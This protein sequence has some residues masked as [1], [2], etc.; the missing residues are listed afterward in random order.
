MTNGTLASMII[1]DLICYRES[2][3]EDI[4]NPSRKGS[5]FTTEFITQNV[6]GLGSI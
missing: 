2:K 3:F 6:N 5:V 4:F 1:R